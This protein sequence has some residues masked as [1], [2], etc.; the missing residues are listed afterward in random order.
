[1][2]VLKKSKKRVKSELKVKKNIPK[3]Q[4][5]V[6]LKRRLSI[7]SRRV[8]S[9]LAILSKRI[10]VKRRVALIDLTFVY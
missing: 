10:L 2:F 9:G 8:T 5:E 4:I 6:R 7:E 3:R 1:M